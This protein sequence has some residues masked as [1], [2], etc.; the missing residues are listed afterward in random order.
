MV[1]LFSS[2]SV[3]GL[4][5]IVTPGVDIGK[6]NPGKEDHLTTV[7]GSAVPQPSPHVT[8]WVS[9]QQEKDLLQR[10]AITCKHGRYNSIIL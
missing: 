6:V 5:D 10:S 9:I 7:S 3:P 2:A 4:E 8:A 1:P